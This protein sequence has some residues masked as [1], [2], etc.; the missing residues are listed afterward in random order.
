M[1]GAGHNEPVYYYL[2]TL[3]VDLLP[4]TVFALPAL[5]AYR[6]Y[7]GIAGEPAALFFLAWFFA[8]VLFFTA[9]DTKRD[10]YLMPALPPAALFVGTYID[11]LAAGRLAQGPVFRGCAYLFFHL[12]WIGA[13]AAPFAALW[14]RADAVWSSLAP[15]LVLA[16][17]GLAG[18]IMIARREPET[19]Y[20]AT[21]LTMLLAAIAASYSILPYMDRYKSGRSFAAA[22]RDKVPERSPLYVYA[23]TMNDFNYYTRREVLPVIGSKDRAQTL[24]SQ[25]PAAYMLV[26]DRDLK[27]IGAIP[28]DRIIARGQVGSET[29]NVVFLG[30]EAPA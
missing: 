15:S 20:R 29:W 22:I 18:V 8:I 11:G 1:A 23:D 19:L 13:L 3:P 6:P 26:K 28:P 9:S 7:R 25:K 5:W 12:L 16:A 14:V 17:G 30:R 27:R 10:L 4:W 2:K 21:A 24:L